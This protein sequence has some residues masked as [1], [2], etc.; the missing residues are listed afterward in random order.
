MKVLDVADGHFDIRL[1]R[2]E[3]DMANNAIN[4]ICNN[5]PTFIPD[6]EFQTRLGHTRD[7]VNELLAEIGDLLSSD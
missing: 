2:D 3:L 5:T 6:W 4:E 7:R 1:T